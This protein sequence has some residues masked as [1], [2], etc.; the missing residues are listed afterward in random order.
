MLTVYTLR[1]IRENEMD[2]S[3]G[4]FGSASNTVVAAAESLAEA[5]SSPTHV[6]K[7]VADSDIRAQLRKTGEVSILSEDGAT[8]LHLNKQ[9]VK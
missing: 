1:E 9:P 5:G 7:I 2:R 3:I 4:V 6:A 8:K